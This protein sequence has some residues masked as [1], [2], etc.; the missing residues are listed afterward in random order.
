M[1]ASP[2]QDGGL[3]AGST[4]SRSRGAVGRASQVLDVVIR[5][6]GAADGQPAAVREPVIRTNVAAGDFWLPSWVRGHV[7]KNTPVREV[8]AEVLERAAASPDEATLVEAQHILNEL[9]RSRDNA[10]VIRAALDRAS[11]I[12]ADGEG[13]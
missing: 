1:P 13:R 9:G 4:G 10:P 7:D 3:D 5:G 12:V 6:G 8:V 2:S 11:Q